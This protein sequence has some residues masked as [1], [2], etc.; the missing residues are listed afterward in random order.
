[1][2]DVREQTNFLMMPFMEYPEDANATTTWERYSP[3][4][5][6]TYAFCRFQHTRL[7]DADPGVSLGPEESLLKRAVEETMGGICG[8]VVDISLAVEGFWQSKFN[9]PQSSN[10]PLITKHTKAELQ[11]W[12]NG[13]EELMAWLG[14]AGEWIGCEEKCAWDETCYIPIWPLIHP[15]DRGSDRRPPGNSTRPEY[16]GGTY[17]TEPP[18]SGL[19]GN[20]IHSPFGGRKTWSQSEADLWEPKCVKSDY[21]YR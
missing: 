4:F 1:M 21:L 6:R 8:V 11:R 3:L 7:L 9:R 19:P 10:S 2:I 13:V 17:P 16:P 18:Y 5:N 14:W 12:A 20:E 15:D